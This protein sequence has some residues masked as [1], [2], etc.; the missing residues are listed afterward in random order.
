MGMVASKSKLNIFFAFDIFIMEVAQG[1]NFNLEQEEDILKFYETYKNQLR[2][3]QNLYI[4]ACNAMIFC[5]QEEESK[6]FAPYNRIVCLEEKRE[7]RDKITFL[8]LITV[9]CTL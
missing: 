6:T 5:E 1:H 9:S 8:I 2:T 3:N 4:E 7:V